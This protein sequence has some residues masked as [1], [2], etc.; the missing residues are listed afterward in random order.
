MAIGIAILLFVKLMNFICRSKKDENAVISF[1]KF[2]L[3]KLAVNKVNKIGLQALAYSPIIDG[4]KVTPK[5]A[6]QDSNLDYKNPLNIDQDH[7]LRSYIYN[8]DLHVLFYKIDD[9][10]IKGYFHDLSTKQ[11]YTGIFKA[12]NNNDPIS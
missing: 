12:E 3:T 7:S 9:L 5:E 10:S 2:I 1:V 6:M 11:V 8:K 4:R